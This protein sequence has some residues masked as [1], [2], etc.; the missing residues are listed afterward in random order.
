MLLIKHV[1]NPLSPKEMSDVLGISDST[2]RKYCLALEKNEYFFS[3]TDNQKRVFF[4]KDLVVLK[5]L[6]ELVKVQNMSMENASLIV[7][8]KYK[9][10]PVEQMNTANDVPEVR[11]SDGI[12]NKLIDEVE[13]LK[14]NQNEL[15]SI[16]KQLLERLDEQQ[17]YINE[18]LDKRDEI[19]R[20]SC[21]ERV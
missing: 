18:R 8:A 16:N 19:G 9:D 2:L 3:R 5:K 12:F 11:S 7:S 4:T 6:K 20:A 15:I 1:E 21:R 14:S 10:E 17:R 13:Q